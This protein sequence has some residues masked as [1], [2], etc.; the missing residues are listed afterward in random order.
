MHSLIDH[1]VRSLQHFAHAMASSS[2]GGRAIAQP[3]SRST[4][5]PRV[6]DSHGSS[7]SSKACGAAT[8]VVV[9]SEVMYGASPAWQPV[10]SAVQP[11][12][13]E[14]SGEP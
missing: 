9:L 7:S 6:S 4:A 12:T 11:V 1:L 2:S 10:G 13:Q 8:L 3:S 5:S 14:Q